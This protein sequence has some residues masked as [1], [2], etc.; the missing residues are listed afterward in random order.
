MSSTRTKR[1][2]AECERISTLQRAAK[3]ER[4]LELDRQWV[5]VARLL[6]KSRLLD[7]RKSKVANKS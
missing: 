2:Q 6:A 1:L 5:R 4:Y 3:G 7:F